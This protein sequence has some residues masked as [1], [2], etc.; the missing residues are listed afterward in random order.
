M[1]LKIF[2]KEN[3]SYKLLIYVYNYLLKIDLLFNN[4]LNLRGHYY[5]KIDSVFYEVWKQVSSLSQA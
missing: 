1:S 3:S 4:L 2:K 5:D